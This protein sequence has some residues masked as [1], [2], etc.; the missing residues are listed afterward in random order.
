M[1]LKNPTALLR[2]FVSSTDH[3][4]QDVLCE[5]IVFAAKNEGISGATVLKGILGY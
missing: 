2:I 5:S 3:V 1:N 4:K